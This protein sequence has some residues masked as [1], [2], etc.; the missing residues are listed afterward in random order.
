MFRIH[1]TLAFLG[2]FIQK[3]VRF[4]SLNIK[5]TG[6]SQCKFFMVPTFFQ[7]PRTNIVY[8]TCYSEVDASK[9]KPK[10]K[11]KIDYYKIYL[12]DEPTTIKRISK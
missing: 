1:V 10:C 9:H 8:G 11:F 7:I 2:Y 4:S 5:F 12:K 6:E 3:N